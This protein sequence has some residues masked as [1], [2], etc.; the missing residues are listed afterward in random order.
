MAVGGWRPASVKE[1]PTAMLPDVAEGDVDGVT[2]GDGEEVPVCVTVGEG[3][4]LT[5]GVAVLEFEME[6]DEVCEGVIDGVAVLE[7]DKVG[8]EEKDGVALAVGESEIVGVGVSDDETEMVG[9]SVP[10]RL[11][12]EVGVPLAPKEPDTLGE[13]VGLAT[14]AESVAEALALAV[15]AGGVRVLL[16]EGDAPGASALADADALPL[17]VGE[18]LAPAAGL[19]LAPPTCVADGEAEAPPPGEADAEGSGSEAEKN[20]ASATSMLAK[21]VGHSNESPALMATPSVF[22]VGSRDSHRHLAKSWDVPFVTT[23]H[24][25]ATPETTGSSLRADCTQWSCM[26]T[27]FTEAAMLPAVM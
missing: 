19:T 13:E 25:Y 5:L 11:S 9:L 17:T 16:A 22:V 18:A 8:D 21:E 1:R 14:A 15:E 3:E 6:G 27:P 10:E 26:I 24:A 12:E 7:V 23:S 4:A 2:D 20:P